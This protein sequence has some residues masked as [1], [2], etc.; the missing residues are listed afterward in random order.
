MSE[1]SIYTRVSPKQRIDRLNA[2]IGRLNSTKKVN[3]IIILTFSYKLINYNFYFS[4]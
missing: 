2:F 1:L 4:F 3:I